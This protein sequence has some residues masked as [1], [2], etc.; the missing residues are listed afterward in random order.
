MIHPQYRAQVDLL[1]SILPH[2]AK[3]DGLALKGGTAI[4]LFVRDMPRLSVDIDLTYLNWEDD[5]TTALQNISNALAR[6]ERRIKAAIPGTSVTK[7]PLGQGQDVKLNCQTPQATVK[8]EVNTITRGIIFPVR[9]MQVSDS[10]QNE[11]GKFAAINVVSHGELFG[12]KI[13]AALDRQHPRDLFDLHHLFLSDGMTDEVKLGFIAFLLSHSR[14]MVE[15]I[16][17]HL[18]DQR[19]TLERHFTGM[20]AAPFPYSTFKAARERLIVEI[21]QALNTDDRKFLV[22]F[23]EGEPLWGLM[24][25]ENLRHLPGVKWKLNNIRSL[26]RGNPSKHA[27]M[28]EM[29]KKTLT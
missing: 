26:M 28:L 14:P 15:L 29:L 27:Q 19:Q 23:K 13:C 9:S 25:I 11:F 7:V 24:P 6:V 22:S 4:N 5:R 16:Q 8:I 1:L 20:T 12:G 21:G 17:P 2:V 3:E 18:L 10:V